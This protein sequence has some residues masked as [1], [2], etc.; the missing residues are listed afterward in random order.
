MRAWLDVAQGLSLKTAERFR[1]LAEMQIIP[2]IG[3]IIV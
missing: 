3:A 1:Q 2:H